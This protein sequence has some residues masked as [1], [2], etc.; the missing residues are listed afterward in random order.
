MHADDKD[1]ETALDGA[2][3]R[4]PRHRAPAALRRQLAQMLAQAPMSDTSPLDAPRPRE[5]FARPLVA[6]LIGGCLAAGLVLAVGRLLPPPSA[7]SV[8]PPLALVD[9]AVNDHL[10]V[11]TSTHPAEVESGGIHQVKPW[12][13]GRLEFAPRVTFAG[14]DEFP[15]LGGSVGYFGDRKAA[16]FLFRH[17]LHAITLL[18]FPPAGLQWPPATPL[19]GA[20]IAVA[21]TSTRGFNAVLWR[22]GDLGYALISDVNAQDL[23]TLAARINPE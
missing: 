19:P 20:R 2:L 6:S 10:R 21:E 4:L 12:F 1:I 22:D 13:T 16:V 18:V 9:E 5:R 11:V 15:L 7:S 17:R 23:R 8:S 3:D 14:D